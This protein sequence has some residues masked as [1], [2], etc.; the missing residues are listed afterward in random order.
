MVLGTIEADCAAVL[1]AATVRAASTVAQ[2]VAEGVVGDGEPLV[3]VVSA[4]P[5]VGATAGVVPAADEVVPAGTGLP[6]PSVPAPPVFCPPPPL[7][8]STV[9]PA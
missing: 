4:C 5:G 3:M 1:G 7:P 6:F 8:V 2:A 9:L